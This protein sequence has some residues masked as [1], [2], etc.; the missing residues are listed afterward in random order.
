MSNE[1][2]QPKQCRDCPAQILWA[3]PM[4]ARGWMILKCGACGATDFT[5][6]ATRGSFA[7]L[8]CP[9]CGVVGEAKP[10]A[11]APINWEPVENGNVLVVERPGVGFLYRVLKKG[12]QPP[13]GRPLRTSHFMDCPNAKGRRAKQTSRSSSRT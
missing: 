10:R 11:G 8:A 4:D 3:R 6:E 2:H 7:E 9:K 1:A 12:E 5:S 13:P